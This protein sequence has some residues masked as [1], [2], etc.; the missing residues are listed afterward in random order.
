MI[1]FKWVWVTLLCIFSIGC[2]LQTGTNSCNLASYSATPTSGKEVS[3]AHSTYGGSSIAQAFLLTTKGIPTQVTVHLQRIGT[4][5]KGS[6]LLTLTIESDSGGAPSTLP[7]ITSSLDPANVATKASFYSFT[8]TSAP[9]LNAAQ[10]YWI[11]I[12]G[13]YAVND[14]DYI[15]WSAYDGLSGGY[16]VG[17]TTLGSVYENT[18]GIFSTALLGTFRF[19]VFSIGC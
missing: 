8:L 1:I 4:F 9:E 14:T 2:N 10:V 7:L 17:T 18:L 3:I 13:S 11:R 19:L 12:K 6:H 5:V 16:S 15:S